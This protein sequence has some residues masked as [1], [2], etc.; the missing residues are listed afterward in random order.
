[1]SERDFV[2]YG[3]HPPEARWPG[4][5]R[6]AISFKFLLPGGF[7]DGES[8][9][10]YLLDTFEQLHEEGGRLMNVGLHARI[11]GRPGRARGLARFL[12]HVAGRDDVWVATRAEIARHWVEQHAPPSS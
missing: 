7:A 3:A 12:D 2:G 8:F 1:V 9:H 11:V 5:A 4:G 6:V 10:R